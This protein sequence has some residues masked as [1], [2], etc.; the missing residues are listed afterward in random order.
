MIQLRF[1][2]G[3]DIDSLG[4][5]PAEVINAVQGAVDAHGRGLTVFEPRTHLVPD[6]GGAGHFNVLRGHVGTLGEHGLSGVKVVGDF[7][8]NYQYGLPSE[9]A[10]ITVYDP[11][12]GVPLA[13]MDAT[14]ITEARTGAMT[15]VGAKFLARP[16]SRIL[17]HV[18]ARGTAF[19]NVTMLDSLFPLDE[20]RVT[21]RRPESREAF[22]AQLRA[23]TD[24]P[25]RAVDTAAEAFEGADIL[26]E[27]SRL[28]EPQPLLRTAAVKPGAFVV[29]YG[30]ISAVELDL[31]DVMD[32]VVVDDWSESRS[33]RFGALRAHV[34]TGRLSEKTLHAQI[35]EIVTG[36]KPGREHPDE[37]ILYWH[38]GLSILDV[39]VAHLILTRAE[40]A[41]TGTLLRYR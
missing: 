1:L 9:L 18:G 33:G 22:A 28:Q 39:A 2:S 14:W 19:S 11:T 31:L 24:T 15:A 26:V 35:G 17:G 37:R 41:D 13:I 5:G 38:R 30:T 29:P 34:D 10:L 8:D 6:N 27:A 23:A 7:V 40:A 16:D 25:V 20:I 21:S 36:R 4:I 32:K 3:P 12:T